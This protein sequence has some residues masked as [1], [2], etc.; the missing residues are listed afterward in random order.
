LD[1]ALEGTSFRERRL[2]MG[3][4]QASHGLG[5]EEIEA[6]KVVSRRREERKRKR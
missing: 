5:L 3:L 4:K 6:W 2:E 1:D